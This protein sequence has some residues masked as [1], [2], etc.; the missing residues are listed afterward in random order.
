MPVL[1]TSVG[2]AY[3]AH[4]SQTER[5]KFLQ[6]VKND[7]E[8]WNRIAH[9]PSRLQGALTRIRKQGFAVMN[10]TYSRKEYE[11]RVSSI[12]VPV[13]AGTTLFGSVNILYLK[14]AFTLAVA[15]KK[16]VRPRQVLA[17]QM[18]TKLAHTFSGAVSY[19]IDEIH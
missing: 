14:N 3:I 17:E 6:Q 9:D 5:D 16:L 2:L 8:P 11:N 4:C 13:M 1:G 15:K 10:E 18:A 12:G 7:P 19:P